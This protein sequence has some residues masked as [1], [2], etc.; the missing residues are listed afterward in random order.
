MLLWLRLAPF[1]LN[2]LPVCGKKTGWT[3]D[4]AQH[5]GPLRQEHEQ[6]RQANQ[7]LQQNRVQLRDQH[8]QLKEEVKELKRLLFGSRKERFVPVPDNQLSLELTPDAAQPAVP[9]K[10]TVHY[11]RIVKQ[12]VKKASRQLFPAHLPRVEVVIE[13][14]SSEECPSHSMCSSSRG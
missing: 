9:L 1:L 11:E 3:A 12:A 8:D 5:W 2:R 4:Q 10:Q 14:Q 7:Q 6:L 13:P